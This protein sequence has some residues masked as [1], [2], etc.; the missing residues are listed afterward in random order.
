MFAWSD[1]QWSSFI[2]VEQSLVNDFL[3]GKQKLFTKFREG[4]DISH[5]IFYDV[6]K[7]M[8]YVMFL[9]LFNHIF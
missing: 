8:N 2:F 7:F 5:V 4:L 6:I 3:L 9:H 1:R